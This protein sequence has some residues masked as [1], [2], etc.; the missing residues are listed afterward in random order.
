MRITRR[1]SIALVCA[2][3][4]VAALCQPLPVAQRPEDVG[5]SSARLE[6]LRS[7]MQ[8]DV[9]SRRIPGAVLLIARQGRVASLMAL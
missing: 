5:F 8:A 6:R 1:S 4:P 7:Q 2:L 3:L 9:E